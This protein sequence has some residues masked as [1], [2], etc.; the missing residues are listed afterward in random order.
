MDM[1]E[2]TP[3]SEPTSGTAPGPE[4]TARPGPESEP[5]QSTTASRTAFRESQHYAA[6]WFVAVAAVLSVWGLWIL[7]FTVRG[8][9]GDEFRGGLAVWAGIVLGLGVGIGLPVALGVLRL[10]T[11]VGTADMVVRLAPF[12]PHGRRVVWSEVAAFCAVRYRPLREYGGWGI[13]GT[14]RNGAYN[15]RG[16]LGVLFLMNDG[17]RLLVGSQ[18]PHELEAAAAAACGREPAA[19]VGDASRLSPG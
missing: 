15:A 11:T 5:V 16:D 9:S 8:L 13:R 2:P 10:T 7:V 6:P 14:R 17:A 3:G 18:R 19:T 12:Q 1:I 4:Q